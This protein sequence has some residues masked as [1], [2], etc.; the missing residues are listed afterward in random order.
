V[1]VR[2]W[3]EDYC[4]TQLELARRL[5]AQPPRVSKWY[6][7]AV[8]RLPELHDRPVEVRNRLAEIE[9]PIQLATGQRIVPDD[10]PVRA[11]CQVE[12]LD[13]R[14]KIVTPPDEW[15]RSLLRPGGR[16]ASL[17]ATILFR[18][19]RVGRRP[20]PVAAQACATFTFKRGHAEGEGG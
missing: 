13:E 20:G 6:S 8:E 1:L 18:A 14:N 10:E 17:I 2:I 7:T 3:V 15:A 11:T 4:R 16:A 5:L 12:V 19:S 9:A